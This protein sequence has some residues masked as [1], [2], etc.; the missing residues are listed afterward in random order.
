[1]NTKSCFFVRRTIISEG[2]FIELETCVDVVAAVEYENGSRGAGGGGGK[3]ENRQ[4]WK[5]FLED[6]RVVL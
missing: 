6:I 3:R 1:M 2:A 4:M 5:Q